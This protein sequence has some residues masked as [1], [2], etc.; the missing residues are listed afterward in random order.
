MSP[1]QTK[2]TKNNKNSQINE[3]PS[4]K[5]NNEDTQLTTAPVYEYIAAPVLSSFSRPFLVQWSEDRRLY[6]R[7]IRTRCNTTGEEVN[8]VMRS[9]L[10][11]M[12]DQL[13][14]TL[15]EAFWNIPKEEVTEEYLEK[16]I[17][18]VLDSLMNG[19]MTIVDEAYSKDLRWNHNEPDAV[20]Q[21]IQYFY[22]FNK[23]SRLNGFDRFYKNDE[24][25]KRKCSLLRK[26]L[27]NEL[28]KRVE[29]EIQYAGAKAKTDVQ[30]LRKVI[31]RYAIQLANEKESSRDRE[32][33]RHKGNSGYHQ[34]YSQQSSDF[35]HKRHQLQGPPQNHSADST[36]S[37]K[38]LRFDKGTTKPNP[39]IKHANKSHTEQT[40][41]GIKCLHC[42]GPHRL[43]DCTK[44]SE[45]EKAKARLNY[46]AKKQEWLQKEEGRPN[47]H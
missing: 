45:A 44:A 22:D 19:R 15:C 30:E 8:V 34:R 39:T 32:T 24:G 46:A 25:K 21:T 31:E 29:N 14:D 4:A 20:A 18:K 47:Q 9:K 3:S 43:R 23:I 37:N 40:R 6:E 27:P 2:Q 13:L 28:S 26:N 12:N 36:P 33:K 41:R 42:E 38:T 16:Q 10:D 7:N 17:D 1:K 11:S 35:Y 5:L